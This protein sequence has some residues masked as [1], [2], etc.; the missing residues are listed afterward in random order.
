[1]SP[2]LLVAAAVSGVLDAQG[3]FRETTGLVGFIE[4]KLDLK[5]GTIT[6]VSFR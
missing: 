1:M 6:S 4:V 3:V 2:P 5:P